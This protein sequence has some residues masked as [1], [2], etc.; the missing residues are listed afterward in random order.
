MNTSDRPTA[1]FV[2]ADGHELARLEIEKQERDYVVGSFTPTER[3]A[4]VKPVFDEF[5]E[6]VDGCCLSHVD[7]LDKQIRAMGIGLRWDADSRLVP[8]HDLQIYP[9][10]GV[11]SCR[12]LVSV[13]I[14]G[15]TPAAEPTDRVPA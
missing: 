4:A 8:I 15:S 6:A 5:E 2:D 12:P 7:V 9:R 10:E 13:E 3:F 11:F 14:N 1:A